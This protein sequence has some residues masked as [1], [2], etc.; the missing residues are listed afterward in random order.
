MSRHRLALI[1]PRSYSISPPAI[2][3]Y[4]YLA[5]T[6]NAATANWGCFDYAHENNCPG[7]YVY[8]QHILRQEEYMLVAHFLDYC[9][10]M[11]VCIYIYQV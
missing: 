7:F 5:T 3:V 2:G 9:Q 4:T 8:A 11:H 1:P 10:T 6:V